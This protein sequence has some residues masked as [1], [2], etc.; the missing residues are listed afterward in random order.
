MQKKKLKQKKYNIRL[1]NKLIYFAKR[2]TSKKRNKKIIHKSKRYHKKQEPTLLQKIR[3][4]RKDYWKQI[5]ERYT[6]NDKREVKNV[7]GEIGIETGNIDSFIKMGSAIIDSNASD[8]YI[9]LLDCTRLWPSAITLLC[10]FD[11]WRNLLYG[12]RTKRH[13]NTKKP[14]IASNQPKNSGLEYYLMHCGFYD[15]INID[16]KRVYTN[17]YDNSE[18]VKIERE[19]DNDNIEFRCKQV[20]DLIKRKSV[21]SEE[22]IEKVQC[23]VVPE[24]IYNVFEHGQN[25]NDN[26]WWLLAQYHKKHKIISICIADNGM[27]FRE[28]LLTGPQREDIKERTKQ[29]ENRDGDF[30]EFAFKEQVSGAVDANI[31]AKTLL[32]TGLPRGANRGNGLKRVFETCIECS[33]QLSVFSQKGYVIFNKDG[34]ILK[35][36]SFESRIFGGTMYN[37]IIPAKQEGEFS[38]NN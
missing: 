15:Y 19:K 6:F 13:V 20:M 10:S 22:E 27:G 9:N 30:I 34:S 21:L 32:S 16:K 11:Q 2:K 8:L 37:L 7:E 38:E 29:F 25:Y 24:I 14:R 3:R 12:I 1:N 17:K 26:G 36:D 35:Q 4:R 28:S 23:K 33:I 5:S 31:R 18:I